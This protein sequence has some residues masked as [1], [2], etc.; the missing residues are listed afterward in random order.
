MRGS[1]RL[2]SVEA[3]RGR[4]GTGR[5]RL[6]TW[7]R[8]NIQSSAWLALLAL[9]LQ[10]AVSFG[11]MHRHDLGLPATDQSRPDANINGRGGGAGRPG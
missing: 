6:M 11:H 5:I 1:I 7:F 4:P 3:A 8:S 2:A 9:T 10:M